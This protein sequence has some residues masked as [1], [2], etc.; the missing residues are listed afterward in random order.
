MTTER[1]EFMTDKKRFPSSTEE[2]NCM[3]ADF[4]FWHFL[5]VAEKVNTDTVEAF[6]NGAVYQ[7]NSDLKALVELCIVLWHKSLQQKSKGNGLLSRYYMAQYMD[8]YDHIKRY[9]DDRQM[10][11]YI[12]ESATKGC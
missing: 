12:I 3:R 2:Q 4:A 8:T 5:T 7:Y 6:C 9:T 1:E 10:M 11:K